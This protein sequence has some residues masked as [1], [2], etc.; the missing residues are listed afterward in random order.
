MR[1]LMP[2]KPMRWNTK[3]RAHPVVGW[4]G[5]GDPLFGGTEGAGLRP[6]ARAYFEVWG[7]SGE[8]AGPQCSGL[9]GPGKLT[10]IPRMK[11]WLQDKAVLPKAG[12]PPPTFP[13]CSGLKG[14]H[15]TRR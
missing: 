14:W 10:E 15:G 13:R 9:R 5:T 6:H 3:A 1:L 4:Q 11:P 2:P 7:I 12:H 8:L